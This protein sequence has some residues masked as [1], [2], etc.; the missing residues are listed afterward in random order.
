M[1]IDKIKERIKMIEENNFNIINEVTTPGSYTKKDFDAIATS[2]DAAKTFYKL[3]KANTHASDA[4]R[5]IKN[6]LSGSNN[7]NIDD[8]KIDLPKD[9]NKEVYSIY[10]LLKKHNILTKEINDVT[11]EAKNSYRITSE[12]NYTI[13][14]KLVLPPYNEI[15]LL[16]KGEINDQSKSNNNKLLSII[17]NLKQFAKEVTKIN[18]FLNELNANKSKYNIKE[19]NKIIDNKYIIKFK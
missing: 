17:I 19:I 1:S 7:V 2:K 4:E 15:E 18:N 13:N 14:N 10:A 16:F 9:Y 8:E 5:L 11:F 3:G 12:K 6:A